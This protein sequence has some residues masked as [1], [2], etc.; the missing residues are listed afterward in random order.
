MPKRSGLGPVFAYEWL[1]ASRRFQM[2]A[3]RSIFVLALLLGM[4]TVCWTQ[5]KGKPSVQFN[6]LANLGEYLFV[7]LTSIQLAVV[8]LSAPAATAGALCL[9][10]ARG[11][12]L[13]LLMTDLSGAEVVLGKLAARLLPV[14]GLMLSS[15]PVLFLCLLLGG[16]DPQ[17]LLGAYLV[18]LGVGLVACSLALT[19]S[20][21]GTKTHEVLLVNY[22]LWALWL[23]AYPVNLLLTRFALIGK[24]SDDLLALNPFWLS[25]APYT[26]PGRSYLSDQFLYLGGS[27][28]LAAALILLSIG[29]VR[30]VTVRQSGRAPRPPRRWLAF[31]YRPRW[32]PGPSLDGNP[33]L[34]RECRRRN[35]SRWGAVVW[36]V[37]AA[38]SFSFSLLAIVLVFD[39]RLNRSAY[40]ISALQV[41]FG[42]LFVCVSAVTCLAEERVHGS[43]DVLLTTPLSASRILWG[44]W[45][46]GFRATLWVVVLPCLI[47]C[48]GVLVSYRFYAPFLLLALLLA[49]GAAL[50]SLGL[51]VATWVARLNRAIGIC[52]T[53]YVMVSIGAIFVMILGR[54]IESE[55]WGVASP[56]FGSAG[57]TALAVLPSEIISHE[58]KYLVAGACG[59]I[60]GYVFVAAFLYWCTLLTFERFVGRSSGKPPVRMPTFE[61]ALS[62][63]CQTENR[64]G[65]VA[66]GP[67][68]E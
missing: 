27:V 13:H 33:V 22:L 34:W 43:L 44:K 40:I 66:P 52:V 23:L 15:A 24:V 2:Y 38:L 45:C 20:V 32:W 68:K 11:T 36:S 30:G 17:A 25:F 28:A 60:V 51:A 56:L 6:D 59:W 19:L 50:T 37:Y 46:G 5:F 54:S 9:D 67:V 18:T 31:S 7:T 62:M 21:W 35:P 65:F 8:L 48:S 58:E 61:N 12:L 4:L 26:R 63:S 16:I 3:L 55:W 47:A 10:K 57:I 29:F 64:V 53:L 1:M 42:L 14:L 49:Y 41:A 39:D